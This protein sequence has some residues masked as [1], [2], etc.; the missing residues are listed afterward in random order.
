MR[1]CNFDIGPICCSGLVDRETEEGDEYDVSVA[2][3]MSHDIVKLCVAAII[4]SGSRTCD[5]Q[6]L[7]LA[8]HH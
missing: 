7:T 4:S 2:G 6:E 8:G 3:G 1:S 5:G